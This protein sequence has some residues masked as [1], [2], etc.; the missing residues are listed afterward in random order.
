MVPG[1][2]GVYNGPSVEGPL[3]PLLGTDTPL[4]TILP[5]MQTIVLLSI[6]YT[7]SP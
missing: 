3:E 7:T 6:N 4:H 1:G 5:L 2:V